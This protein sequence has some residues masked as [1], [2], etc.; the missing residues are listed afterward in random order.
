MSDW[1]YDETR[2]LERG[3]GSN[4]RTVLLAPSSFLFPIVAG[5]VYL[6]ILH[7]L[8]FFIIRFLVISFPPKLVFLTPS[9]LIVALLNHSPLGSKSQ[10]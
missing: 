4:C 8:Q 5:H 3:L 10:R 2:Y 7:H 9:R 6:D 1:I